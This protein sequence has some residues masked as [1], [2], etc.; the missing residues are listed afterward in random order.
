MSKLWFNANSEKQVIDFDVES[1]SRAIQ[2]GSTPIKP[3]IIRPVDR[4][5][6]QRPGV[7][8]HPDETRTS[9]TPSALQRS[10]RAK[11]QNHIERYGP[12]TTTD[13]G[14]KTLVSVPLCCL[15][16]WGCC[17]KATFLNG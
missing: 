16:N 15:W 10:N 7:P 8:M 5:A 11:L 2:K 12:P 1:E 6:P 14:Q 9:Q 17:K 13:G 4:M 3:V